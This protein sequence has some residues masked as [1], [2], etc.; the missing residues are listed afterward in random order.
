MIFNF[1]RKSEQD[2][3]WVGM[4][5]ETAHQLGTPISALLAWHE[6]IKDREDLQEIML[7]VQKDLSR[8]EM[9]TQRFSKIGSIPELREENNVAKQNIQSRANN[10]IPTSR[11]LNSQ[12]P[13]MP[14]FKNMPAPGMPVGAPPIP[15]GAPT[16]KMDLKA[17]ALSAPIPESDL[18]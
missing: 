2:Q 4:S 3:V 16:V 5:K 8:L 6:L 10:P 1:G 17:Q 18:K 14:D 11:P 15:V 9:I 7:E 12:A 13:G